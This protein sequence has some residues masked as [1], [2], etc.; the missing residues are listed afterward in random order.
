MGPL[1]RLLSTLVAVSPLFVG[2]HAEGLE[3]KPAEIR[4][5]IEQPPASSV[6]STA[7]EV[8]ALVLSN[9]IAASFI[10]RGWYSDVSPKSGWRSQGAIKNDTIVLFE[11][12]GPKLRFS[13]VT[14]MDFPDAGRRYELRVWRG[15]EHKD[16]LTIDIKGDRRAPDLAAFIAGPRSDNAE[17]APDSD[18]MLLAEVD[19][20]G[21][22][23]VVPVAEWR[24]GLR[25]E[26]RQW[27]QSAVDEDFRKALQAIAV[28]TKGEPELVML[29][30][31]VLTP[32]LGKD[33]PNCDRIDQSFVDYAG[34]PDCDF[35]SWFGETC[36]LE[37][38]KRFKCRKNPQ[39]NVSKAP[40]R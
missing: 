17:G 2:T 23:L 40:S 5:H 20:A 3:L 31:L 25:G 26:D 33:A 14:K 15:P 1:A 30:D 21:R 28:I 37:T 38:L 22:R 9:R 11:L 29:C 19:F 39:L 24:E 34:G 16:S 8:E 36:P 35:D 27:L 32:I 18:E 7:T 4:K 10:M 12:A 6:P 13:W